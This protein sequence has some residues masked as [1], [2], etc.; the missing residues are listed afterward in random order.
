MVD[1]VSKKIQKKNMPCLNF[2]TKVLKV[3]ACLPGKGLI[4]LVE[5]LNLIWF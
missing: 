5:S 1:R 4:I 3:L 2:L